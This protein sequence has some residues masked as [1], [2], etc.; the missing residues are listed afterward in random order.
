MVRECCRPPRSTAGTCH[1]PSLLTIDLAEQQALAERLAACP[2]Q[3]I[4]IPLAH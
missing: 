4:T 3:P 1:A 2:D